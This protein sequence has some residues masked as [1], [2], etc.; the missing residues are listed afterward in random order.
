MTWIER[1]S[2]L[3]RTVDEAL[4]AGSAVLAR[5]VVTL[6]AKRS[7]VGWVEGSAWCLLERHDVIHPSRADSADEGLAHDATIIIAGD[8]TPSHPPP[9]RL[10][11]EPGHGRGVCLPLKPNVKKN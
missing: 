7:Q 2:S 4:G 8:D 1:Q 5:S 9:Y 11:V 10:V 3:I 6:C